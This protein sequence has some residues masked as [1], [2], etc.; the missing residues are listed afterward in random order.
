MKFK[1]L[2][3]LGLAGL[4]V[5]GWLALVLT[6]PPI[7]WDQLLFGI[8]LVLLLGIFT[9]FSE[10]HSAP[11]NEPPSALDITQRLEQGQISEEE[12]IDLL[13]YYANAELIRLAG[14]RNI[15]KRPTK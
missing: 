5:F 11:Q 2:M 1:K 4:L 12:A 7:A 14:K 10:I 3:L 6:T 15:L 9:W 13:H 8:G